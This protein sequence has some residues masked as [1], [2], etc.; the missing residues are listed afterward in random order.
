MPR[1]ELMDLLFESFEEYPYW[2]IKGLRARVEQPEVYL[3][4]VLSSVADL[5]KRGP[6]TGN[7]SLRPQ[8][9]ELRKLADRRGSEGVKVTEQ[10]HQEVGQKAVVG[11]SGS[12]TNTPMIKAEAGEGQG[13]ENEDI[14]N[15]VG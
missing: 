15:I 6:Y 11:G 12:Y 9:A 8:Y 1:N 2:S 7:W 10:Q 3:R 4:E 14:P 5:H 13:I